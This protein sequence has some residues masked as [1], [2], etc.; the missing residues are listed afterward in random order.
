V[1]LVGLLAYTLAAAALWKL[2]EARFGRV[3]GRMP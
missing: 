1:A 2:T 3:T